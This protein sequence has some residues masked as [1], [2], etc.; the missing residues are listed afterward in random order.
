MMDEIS[1]SLWTTLSY[2]LS[3]KKSEK[4]EASVKRPGSRKVHC[5]RKSRRTATSMQ[6]APGNTTGLTEAFM[7]L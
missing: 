5:S 6:H 7:G 2:R 4:E 3:V 1:G